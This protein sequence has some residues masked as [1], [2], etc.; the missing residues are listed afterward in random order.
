M[1]NTSIQQLADIKHKIKHPFGLFS[2]NFKQKAVG[3]KA[4]SINPGLERQDVSGNK[5]LV[6]KGVIWR[7]CVFHTVMYICQIVCKP[8]GGK[9]RQHSYL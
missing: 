6:T 5:F 8:F 9:K 2:I 7:H 3:I 4:I 1:R